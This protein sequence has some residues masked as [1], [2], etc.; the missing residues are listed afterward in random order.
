MK[1]SVSPLVIGVIAVLA[2]LVIGF[3]GFK[4]FAGGSQDPGAPTEAQ[5]SQRMK[6]AMGK[7]SGQAGGPPS[8]NNSRR[9]G[10]GSYGSGSSSSGGSYGGGGPR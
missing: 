6:D 10:S 8:T 5:Q 7:Y 2:V 1:Q 9:M 4:V 3:I